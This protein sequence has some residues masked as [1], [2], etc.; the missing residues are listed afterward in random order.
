MADDNDSYFS[1]EKPQVQYLRQRRAFND[2]YSA[3]VAEQAVVS[4][5][6][7][8]FE[9]ALNDQIQR[10]EGETVGVRPNELDRVAKI[11]DELTQAITLIKT[12]PPDSFRYADESNDVNTPA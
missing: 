7:Y 9:D 4:F 8:S 2:A 6:S 11:E 5:M 1:I 3:I 12:L 10:I